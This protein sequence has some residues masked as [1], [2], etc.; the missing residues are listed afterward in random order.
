ME[1]VSLLDKLVIEEVKTQSD[2]L[3]GKIKNMIVTRE[4]DESFVFPNENDCCKRLNVSRSTLREAYKILDTQGF[5]HR[6]KHG[7]Y[8]KCRDDIARQGNFVASLE[9]A[10]EQE[11]FEFVSALEPD[12]ASLA[13]KKIDAA[14]IAKLKTLMEACEE[15]V[16]NWK[17]LLKKNYQFHA[18]IRE[19]AGNNLITS[20][21]IAYY[22]IFNQQI[23]T[24][25]YAQNEDIGEFREN[26]LKQHR[27]L[28]E[29]IKNHDGEKAKAIEYQHLLDDIEFREIRSEDK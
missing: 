29:A 2:Y 23:I 3:A 24:G 10:E 17:G 25:I 19:L 26:S 12:A 9:L 8:V 18:Y 4:L 1:N 11:L 6:T 27:E 16:D 14:G 15:E 22:D 13:A 28:F 20:A 5:I 7:T 21:L